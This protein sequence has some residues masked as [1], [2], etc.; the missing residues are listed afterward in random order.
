MAEKVSEGAT[1]HDFVAETK[2]SEVLETAN[3]DAPDRR[4]A[5]A[6]NIVE[7][8]LTVSLAMF[9]RFLTA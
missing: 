3:P 2:A 5:A 8:P 4:Q 6:L 1:A 7:N 9:A